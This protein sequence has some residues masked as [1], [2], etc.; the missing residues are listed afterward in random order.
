MEAAER[1]PHWKR[2][3]LIA[4]IAIIAHAA[5]LGSGWIWDDDSYVTA[6]AL[7]SSDSGFVDAFIPGSTPQYYPLVFAGLWIQSAFVGT[8]PFAYHLVN[9]LMHA[10][11]AVLLVVVLTRLGVRHAFWIGA[12]FAAHPMGVESV[13]WVTERKNVQSMLFALASVLIYLR[14]LDAP[15]GRVLGTWLAS[16]LLFACALLSK[17]T[18]IFVPPCLILAVLWMRRPIGARF[19]ASVVPFFVAGIA[20]GLF[21][22]YVERTIVGATG[23]EFSYSILE[24]LQIA[25]HTAAFYL[26]RFVLPTEQ[27]FIYPRFTPDVASLFAWVPFVLGLI[28]LAAS[29]RWWGR[30]RAPFLMLLWYGAAL[31]PALGFFDVWPFRYSFVADHFAYAAMP[32]L[33]LGCV[34]LVTTG[35]AK[36]PA[37]VATIATIVTIVACIALG[38]RATAKYEN[39]E[40]LW[41]DTARRNPEAWIAHNNLASIEL[42][43]AGE[44]VTRGDST[45]VRVHATN[46][47]ERATR[48]GELKPDEAS[49][50]ANR[51]EAHR[52]LG[53]LGASL[54]EIERATELQPKHADFQWSRARVLELMGRTDDARMAFELCAS[55]G[56]GTRDEAT[57]RRDLMRLAIAR[58]DNV[59]AVRQCRALLTLEPRNPDVI[60]NFGALLVKSGDTEQA[61]REFRRALALRPFFSSERALVSTSLG[62]L[63][64]VIDTRPDSAELAE[65][66]AAVDTLRSFAP[67]DPG[68]RFL[69]LAVRLIGGDASARAEIEQMERDARAAGGADATAFADQVAA[70]L[71]RKPIDAR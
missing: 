54:R 28:A 49:N 11:N 23:E 17:T 16:F 60:A 31:F 38:W 19:I 41:L 46:A 50:A 52:L 56:A 57:A 12:L 59:E 64:L 29:I 3:L 51:S 30:R 15:K 37:R 34:V 70:F 6:N 9:V 32:V 47:L 22:A 24:R 42:R 58:N 13:A 21:T 4:L 7:M 66:R 26:V 40:T 25:G 20:A 5:S 55:L 14:F 62:Y 61:R 35:L 68:T 63:R 36:T 48:A 33:A 53:D 8:E 27:I 71:A 44:A 67:N 10:A 1:P 2:L 18:A 69:D 65:A 43:R 45:A 39:E